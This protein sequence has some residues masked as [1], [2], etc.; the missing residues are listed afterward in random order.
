LSEPVLIEV[1]NRKMKGDIFEAKLRRLCQKAL[2]GDVRATVRC[3]KLAEKYGVLSTPERP[4]HYP[5][6]AVLTI[7]YDWDKAVFIAMYKKHG[8]PPWPGERDGLI[9]PERR[10]K[11]NPQGLTVA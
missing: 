5:G 3:I 9:P 1:G 6:G 11:W 7:P 10:T 8:D 4:E 2:M